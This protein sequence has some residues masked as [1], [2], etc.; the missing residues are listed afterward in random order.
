MCE[1]NMETTASFSTNYIV[2]D[3]GNL[4]YNYSIVPLSDSHDLE[5]ARHKSL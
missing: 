2:P 1:K 3:I 5:R 4:I